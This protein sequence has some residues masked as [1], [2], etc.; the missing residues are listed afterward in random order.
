MTQRNPTAKRPV[1]IYWTKMV[2]ELNLDYWQAR[3]A[4]HFKA[5]AA[6][7]RSNFGAPPVFALEHGLDESE[8]EALSRAV[9]AYIGSRTPSWQHR[10]PWIVYAAEVGYG[11]SGSEYWQTF[12]KK[13][14]GWRDYGERSWIRKCYF[15]F[16][17][18]YGGATPS[19]QWAD[20]FTIIC[21]P[22]THAVLPK[23]LQYQLARVLY[24]VRRSFSKE[25]FEYPAVLGQL[26][27]TRSWAESSR[28][29]N[30][31]QETEL[32]GQIATALLLEGDSGTKGLLHPSTLSRIS[33]DL[34]RKRQGREWLQKARRSA[35]QQA[36]ISGLARY[37][38]PT[39]KLRRTKEARAEVATL[40]IEPRLILRPAD[41]EGTSWRVAIEILDLLDLPQRF[42]SVRD[43]LIGSR[44]NVA[45]HE[46]RPIARGG[47]LYGA[48][49]VVLSRWPKPDEVLLQFEQSHP[50]LEFLLKTEC[51]LRPGPPWLFRIAS[52]GLA[53][54]C[55]GLR[56]RPG[57]RYIVLTTTETPALA[58]VVQ[59][60][61]VQ[62]QGIYGTLLNLPVALN[63]RLEQIVQDLGLAQSRSIEV[64]PAG[65]AA[66]LWDGEGYGEWLAGE[67]PILGIQADH[68]L[69]MIRVS[70]DGQPDST[71]EVTGFTPGK[72]LFLELPPLAMGL[73]KIRVETTGTEG[74][75]DENLGHLKILMR[76]REMRPWHHGVSPS[77]PLAVRIDPVAPT[78]EQ[79]WDGQVDVEI[80]GPCERKVKCDISLLDRGKTRPTARIT[81]SL[82]LPVSPIQWRSFFETHFRSEKRVHKKYDATYECRVDVTAGELGA[83]SFSC[84][85]EFTP[86]RW[87]LSERN[88]NPIVRL[89]DDSG[90]VEDPQVSHFS[91]EKPASEAR[92]DFASEYEVR[93]PGGLYLARQGE[94]STGIIV[95]L[96]VVRSFSDLTISPVIEHR[97]RSLGTV[98]DTVKLGYK[99]AAARSSGDILS[100]TKRRKSLQVI[101]QHV[102]GLVGGEN[103]AR[104][105]SEF[106]STHNLA[107]LERAVTK[108]SDEVN[109]AISLAREVADL[110]EVSIDQRVRRLAELARE[111]RLLSAREGD[112]AQLHNPTWMAEFALRLASSPKDAFEWAGSHLEAAIKYLMEAPVIARAARF[113]IIV[114]EDEFEEEHS[115]PDEVYAGWRWP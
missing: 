9:R 2:T 7:R 25:V 48:R 27:A 76:V 38:S 94:F 54:E 81:Q 104:A 19:G 41:A 28:F 59:T 30:L 91:F 103:W 43:V 75:D 72:P 8:V 97:D 111:H 112:I 45:G 56:I 68:P 114:I 23:D 46:G 10:L 50:D 64:W 109:L 37:P 99:W 58:G 47:F 65:L 57:Q 98:L 86:I 60:V 4:S 26:I 106:E 84:E 63:S 55:R 101:T 66:A 87:A 105:E 42:P 51:L 33:D 32:L 21:W 70:L 39:P 3:L 88:Q 96:R 29:Q 22:I 74:A 115:T 52:D 82:G 14:P 69:D 15:W 34:D 108:Q 62:C 49:S 16:R 61:D 53:Y 107:V 20:W 11:Y 5:L 89:I 78:L 6:E 17:D 110:A 92:L 93:A 100:V 85:R 79:L 1:R 67:R 80:L 90:R 13:T 71:L 95:A 73:H 44:C 36:A 24:E 35:K 12:E 31:V 102:V 18:E 83:F 77:G 113:M 40:G